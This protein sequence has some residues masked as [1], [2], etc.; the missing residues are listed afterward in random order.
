[1]CTVG[2]SSVLSQHRKTSPTLAWDRKW[3]VGVAK[4]L[5]SLVTWPG[6]GLCCLRGASWGLPGLA[7]GTPVSHVHHEAQGSPGPRQLVS[8]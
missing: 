4:A 5:M 1:M 6:L 7:V 2:S 8:G 3:F